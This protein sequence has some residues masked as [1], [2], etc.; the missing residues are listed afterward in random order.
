LTKN[1][2]SKKYILSAVL[3]LAFLAVAAACGGIAQSSDAAEWTVTSQKDSGEGSLRDAIGNA[4]SGG[5]ITFAADVK[6]ITLLS[7]ISFAKSNITIDG[8]SAV[9]ITKDEK[10]K[11]HLLCSTSTTGTLTLKGLT[12]TNGNTVSGHGGG[13]YAESNV[14]LVGCMFDNNITAGDGGGVYANGDVRLS[15]CRFT[16]NKAD[17]GGAVFA[18]SNAEM[19][20]CLFI[21]N[22][23]AR[24]GGGTAATDFK[25]TDCTFDGNIAPDGGGGIYAA[26]DAEMTGCWFEGNKADEYGGGIYILG[27]A[28]LLRCSFNDNLPG[29][30]ETPGVYTQG[31]L[32]QDECKYEA[33][34]RTKDNQDW[35]IIGIAAM[36]IIAGLVAVVVVLQ[37]NGKIK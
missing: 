9:T 15:D 23:A 5:T 10:D 1:S 13:V 26:G 6:T 21:D 19:E 28:V 12:I 34:K 36:S 4:D 18:S 2:R 8:K 35:L 25:M 37:I 29:G 24:T 20:S 11:F 7:E 14:I 3:V 16:N 32:E 30:G 22:E 31:E 27:N 17:H 33:N